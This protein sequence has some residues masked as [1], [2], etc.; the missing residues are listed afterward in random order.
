M[1]EDILDGYGGRDLD[2]VG[3]SEEEPYCRTNDQIRAYML[4]KRIVVY[5]AQSFLSE[6]SKSPNENELV[7]YLTPIL[8]KRLDFRLHK[9]VNAV[10]QEV[11]MG[12]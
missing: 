7:T 4:D 10:M 12:L 6:E 8:E 9:S 2:N 5:T 11:A 1:I 3:T